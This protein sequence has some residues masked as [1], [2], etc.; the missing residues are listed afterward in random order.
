MHIVNADNCT[1]DQ[2]VFLSTE[3]ANSVLERNWAW[4][5]VGYGIIL[6]G[7][8][9]HFEDALGS[10]YDI[11]FTLKTIHGEIPISLND[12]CHPIL[13]ISIHNESFES[14]LTFPA[15]A[16][17]KPLDDFFLW[18]IASDICETMQ[19]PA[20]VESLEKAAADV[21]FSDELE[22]V[23]RSDVKVAYSG[24]FRS[25]IPV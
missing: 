19:S 20:N 18:A 2:R 14:R 15:E 3:F 21:I 4:F 5:E 22:T 17:L 11:N 16:L 12:V 23:D 8:D 1:E 9:Y 7:C 10:V 13:T 24:P 6:P 25:L